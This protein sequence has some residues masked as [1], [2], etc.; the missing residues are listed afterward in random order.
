MS[1]APKR[2]PK[3]AKL[4]R[5]DR[6]RNKKM[7]VPSI[8]QFP[9]VAP[10]E[11]P[12]HEFVITESERQ[13]ES[14][15]ERST[16]KRRPPKELRVVAPAT[17]SAP[18]TIETYQRTWS[19]KKEDTLYFLYMADDQRFI[20]VPGKPVFLPEPWDKY[21]FC[22]HRPVKSYDVDD[23]GYGEVEFEPKGWRITEALT[24]NKV[25]QA[26]T[27]MKAISRA[28]QRLATAL[29]DG[30][31]YHRVVRP[32]LNLGRISPR[33]TLVHTETAERAVNK[34]QRRRARRAKKS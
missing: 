21:D 8:S 31:D 25:A 20:A 16:R 10:D 17:P 15:Y 1:P 9:T 19:G 30:R 13:E 12:E 28:R 7:D 24:G 29:D 23:E 3:A 5:K 14:A 11:I 32:F 4:V 6:H 27:R 22:V 2:I 33:F 18:P 34:E 26:G